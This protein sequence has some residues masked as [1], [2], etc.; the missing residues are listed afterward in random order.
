MARRCRGSRSSKRPSPENSA[1]AIE[2]FSPAPKFSTRHTIMTRC[3]MLSC[4]VTQ[5]LNESVAR[6]TG[7][8]AETAAVDHGGSWTGVRRPGARCLGVPGGSVPEL[9]RPGK[10]VENAY[11]QSYNPQP[12]Q[13]APAV[14]ETVSDGWRLRHMRALGRKISL[15][16]QQWPCENLSA[17]PDTQSQACRAPKSRECRPAPTSR[18]D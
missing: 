3:S 13:P 2:A 6:A 8:S 14:I 4:S 9:I 10:P 17:V 5:R 1:Y 18:A 12:A 7:R 11:I 15:A 16:P